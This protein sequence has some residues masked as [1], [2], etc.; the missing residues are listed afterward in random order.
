MTQLLCALDDWTETLDSGNSVDVLYLDFKKAFDSV[1]HERLLKKIYAYG[2]RGDLFNW[3]QD[4]LKGRRQR[5][6]VNGS[7]SGWSDVISGIPQGSV[8]GP[9]F[10][11][12]FIN[13]LPSLLRNKVL[14]FADDTKIY[15]SI[16]RANPISSLQDDINA[17]I[18]W[19]VMWQLPFN[20]SK[21]K[22]LHIGQF[23]PRYCYK[24]DGMD[25]VKVNEEKDL[26]VL[27][28]CNL[29]FHSQ[30]SAVVNK[31][32]RLL[33]LIKQTFSDILHVYTNQ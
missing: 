11:A 12:I 16:S 1:P 10:F 13:D 5:V 29:K 26:G 7:M 8:L 6:S 22:I 24:M 19:S 2:F 28:D 31:A 18:E 9:L 27:I 3:I 33:G 17:C 15:S 4:F 20:I 32:N 30:C 23:N 21:C 14:L 25:I